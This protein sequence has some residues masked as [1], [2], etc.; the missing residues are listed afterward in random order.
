MLQTLQKL[1]VK[2]NLEKHSA[3]KTLRDFATLRAKKLR[4]TPCKTLRN[5]VLQKL[6][7]LREKLKNFALKKTLRNLVY[8]FVKLCATKTLR[9]RDFARNKLRAKLIET[10]CYQNP[11]RLRDFASKKSP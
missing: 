4:D 10:K 7:K 2:K 9:L 3:T 6:Q 11:S 1:C 8:Y 5:F